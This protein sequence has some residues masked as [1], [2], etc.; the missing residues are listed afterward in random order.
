MVER[1]VGAFQKHARVAFEFL[2]QKRR[3]AGTDRQIFYSAREMA[4]GWMPC[5]VHEQREMLRDLRAQRENTV[6]IPT[7][8]EARARERLESAVGHLPDGAGALKRVE[9]GRDACLTRIPFDEGREGGR[10]TIAL[11]QRRATH[12]VV[13]VAI[14]P[15]AAQDPLAAL[16]S[17][18]SRARFAFI[19][20]QNRGHLGA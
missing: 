10:G 18:V 8:R 6:S 4:I 5:I 13:K 11:Q 14:V 19:A 12:P 15:P 17:I 16:S 3:V 7:P 2:T 20:R 9:C 1:D